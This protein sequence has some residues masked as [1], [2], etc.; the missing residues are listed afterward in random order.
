VGGC[1]SDQDARGGA[2]R[3]RRARRIS[4]SLTLSE[5]VDEPGTL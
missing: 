1:G 4:R 2:E 5:R 3:L